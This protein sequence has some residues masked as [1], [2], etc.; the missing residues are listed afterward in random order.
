MRVNFIV[1]NTKLVKN[2]YRSTPDSY[3]RIQVNNSRI[4]V[5]NGGGWDVYSKPTFLGDPTVKI[6][7]NTLKYLVFDGQLT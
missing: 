4:T 2:P 6:G 5:W 7:G 1:R 3:L